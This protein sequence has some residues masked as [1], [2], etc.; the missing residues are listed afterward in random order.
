MPHG[1]TPTHI[2]NFV[3]SGDNNQDGLW[4]YKRAKRTAGRNIDIISP[5]MD[6]DG[7]ETPIRAFEVSDL[8]AYEWSLKSGRFDPGIPQKERQSLT[9]ILAPVREYPQAFRNAHLIHSELNENG[10]ALTCMNRGVAAR[11]RA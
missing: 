6:V 10:I 8:V 7:V 5:V 11:K 9:A 4:A 1:V 3:A 2:M